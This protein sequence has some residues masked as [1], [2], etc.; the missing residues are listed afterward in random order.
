MCSMCTIKDSVN[1]T[2][3]LFNG[4][5]MVLVSMVW[6]CMLCMICN[7]AGNTWY[8]MVIGEVKIGMAVTRGGIH[9]MV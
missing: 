8:G 4:L 5:L 7:V 9:S 6:C 2:D 1:L 3:V